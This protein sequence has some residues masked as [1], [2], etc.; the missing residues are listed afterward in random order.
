MPH[1]GGMR[2]AGEDAHNDVELLNWMVK[3]VERNVGTQ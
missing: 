1:V 3:V 2:I